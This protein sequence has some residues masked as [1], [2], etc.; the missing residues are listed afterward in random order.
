VISATLINCELSDAGASLYGELITL[1]EDQ[2]K[3]V[4]EFC[5]GCSAFR[6]RLSSCW[7]FSGIN[8]GE[9]NGTCQSIGACNGRDSQ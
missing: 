6:F 3:W 5:S 8:G 2:E 9:P 1:W 4:V 7:R